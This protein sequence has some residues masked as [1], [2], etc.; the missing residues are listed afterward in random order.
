MLLGVPSYQTAA[1]MRDAGLK[2]ELSQIVPVA[3]GSPTHDLL[4]PRDVVGERFRLY[5][6]VAS[7]GL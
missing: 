1:K 6:L 2:V 4:P 3:V 5:A 7:H